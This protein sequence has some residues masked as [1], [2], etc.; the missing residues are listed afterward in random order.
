MINL[1][2][3]ILYLLRQHNERVGFPRRKT[4]LVKKLVPYLRGS[5][6]VLDFGCSDGS[7]AYLMS[8]RLPGVKFVGIDTVLQTKQYI[9]TYQYDGKRLP[10]KDNSFDSVLII[11]VL[12]H[13][14][15][16]DELLREAKRVARKNVL[17]KDHYWD[18]RFDFLALKV[19]DYIGNKPYGISLPYNYLRLNQWEEIIEDLGLRPTVKYQYVNSLWFC[20]HIVINLE[21]VT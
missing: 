20:K 3:P 9:K 4:D 5:R 11:D 17:I 16:P 7:L 6:S 12:H 19:S 21:K 10:F 15:K 8:N 1:Q 14:L 2:T 13:D 18:N